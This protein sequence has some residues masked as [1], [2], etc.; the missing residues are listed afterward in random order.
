MH[1]KYLDLI[2][3]GLMSNGNSILQSM[4]LNKTD[5]KNHFR[6]H[7]HWGK[8]TLSQARLLSVKISWRTL[9]IILPLKMTLE[10]TSPL[11]EILTIL[12]LK[13]SPSP[14]LGT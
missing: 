3:Y 11:L 7:F 5:Y 8:W 10:I 13:M 12:L 6:E 2:A 9:L 4:E 14:I 1:T